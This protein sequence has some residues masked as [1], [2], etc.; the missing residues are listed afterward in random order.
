M[1]AFCKELIDG[2]CVCPPDYAFS[3]LSIRGRGKP[4]RKPTG[5]RLQITAKTQAT[6]LYGINS[7]NVAVGGLGPTVDDPG[8]AGTF[9][10]GISD[11]QSL[12]GYF[13][14]MPSSADPGY[15]AR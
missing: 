8:L 4:R 9:G 2:V 6:N 1:N 14:A 10:E 15:T 13:Q 7:V 12:A 11:M 3:R 5:S